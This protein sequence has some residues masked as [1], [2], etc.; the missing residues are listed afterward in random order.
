[1]KFICKKINLKKNQNENQK[2]TL[3]EEDIGRINE[4]I[5]L[6]N[7]RISLLDDEFILLVEKAENDNN[8]SSIS[9]AKAMKHK[10]SEKNK[11]LTDLENPLKVAR[12]KCRKLV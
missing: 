12:E 6:V 7:K 10:S 1:M 9:T 11:E 2:Q 5:E 8:I 4:K 3:I